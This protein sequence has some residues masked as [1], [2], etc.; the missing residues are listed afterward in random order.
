MAK[1]KVTKQIKKRGVLMF[2]NYTTNQVVLPLDFSF[3]LEKNDIAL[4]IDALIESIPEQRFIPFHHQMGT[5][6]YHSKMMMKM[7]L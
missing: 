7:I 1:I 5:S 2:K 6:S 4:V 3:Q